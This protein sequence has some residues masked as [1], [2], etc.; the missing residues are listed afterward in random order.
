MNINT[1][2]GMRVLRHKPWQHRNPQKIKLMSQA[3]YGAGHKSGIGQNNLLQAPG[4]RIP[5][6]GGQKIRFRQTAYDFLVE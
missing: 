6:I 4:R 5:V 3:V 1:G 2:F